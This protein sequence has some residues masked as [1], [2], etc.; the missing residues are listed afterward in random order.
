[1][2]GNKSDKIADMLRIKALISFKK[3]DFHETL[4][5]LNKS[6]CFASPRSPVSALIF[7]SRADVFY[8]LSFYDKCLNNVTLARS[9]N[10][11]NI[12]ED[13]NELEEKCMENFDKQVAIEN[14]WDFFKL[15]HKSNPKMPA[16]VDC[17]EV[18]RDELYGRHIIT[19]RDLAAGEIL[20]IEKPFFKYLKVDREDVE[21]PETNVYNY[22]AKCLSDNYLDLISCPACTNTMFCNEKCYNEGMASFH[23]YEC[24]IESV[25]EETGSMRMALRSFFH[26][27]FISGGSIEKLKQLMRISDLKNPTI[28]DYDLSE[29]ENDENENYLKCMISLAHNTNVA[30]IKDFSDVFSQN[31]HLKEL[32]TLHKDFINE[33]IIRMH[34]I[35]ILNFHGIKGRSLKKRGD[36]FRSSVGD[37]SYAFCS[38]INHS[39]CPNVM[40]IVVDSCMVLIVERPVKANEQIFDCYIGDSFYYKA[41]KFRQD[42]LQDYNFNC[43]CAACLNQY[44]DLVSGLL[45]IG[46]LKVLQNIQRE[47]HKLQDPRRELS[48]DEAKKLIFKYSAMLN[49]I[50]D[51]KSYPLREVVLLQLCV[52]KCFL[53][54]SRSSLLFP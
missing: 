37:G 51:E 40:R 2:I 39:C 36:R 52:V 48:P 27:L 42:E 23:Q 50:Y 33:Y 28:L 13:L 35:E 30:L 14:P 3:E 5:Q 22:C 53:T 12:K 7:K 11:V 10:C 43:E 24:N 41:K 4:M 19:T 20:A 34:Q 29:D 9:C 45:K 38:L 17:L 32:W 1:M 8:E 6:L 21:Y 31:S 25:L 49:T 16:V 15:S 46:D 47:Y 26:S 44:P 18:R 54:A